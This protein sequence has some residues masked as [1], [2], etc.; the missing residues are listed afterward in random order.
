[1]RLVRAL[2]VFSLSVGFGAVVMHTHP[3]LK[4]RAGVSACPPPPRHCAALATA[5][6]EAVHA[7]ERRGADAAALRDIE[8]DLRHAARVC[9]EAQVWQSATGLVDQAS[10]LASWRAAIG[11]FT[12]VSAPE[13]GMCLDPRSGEPLPGRA[14]IAHFEM[15]ERVTRDYA[16]GD[17]GAK[18][19]AMTVSAGADR[20]RPLTPQAA[21]CA[22]FV[23]AAIERGRAGLR[24]ME[25][26]RHTDAK[27]ALAAGLSA[28]NAAGEACPDGYDDAL[29]APRRALS[30]VLADEIGDLAT[31]LPHPQSPEVL[32][33]RRAL[34]EESLS[35][36]AEL[37]ALQQL[38]EHPALGHHVSHDRIVVA[39]AYQP[40]GL[41]HPAFGQPG[42]GLRT[43]ETLIFNPS[44]GDHRGDEARPL[45]LVSAEGFTQQQQR[46]GFRPTDGLRQ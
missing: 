25:L 26:G 36:L 13:A 21:K 11:D 9:V 3:D 37:R 31:A 27:L 7:A 5:A 12:P 15:Y 18:P 24:R 16:T 44:I 28:F 40:L 2:V 10:D 39:Q 38:G 30:R 4:T 14:L 20:V 43:G 6:L 34:R 1:M 22:L 45:S 17:A 19:L 33:L 46:V 32:D 29:G 41:E 35:K 42:D 23:T 8:A